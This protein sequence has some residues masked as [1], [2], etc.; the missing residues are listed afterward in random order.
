MIML[1]GFFGLATYDTQGF[2]ILE[3]K[4]LPIQAILCAKLNANALNLFRSFFILVITQ[5]F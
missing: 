1:I 5:S 2:G 3:L 4:L